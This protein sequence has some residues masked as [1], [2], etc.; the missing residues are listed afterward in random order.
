MA[1]QKWHLSHQLVPFPYLTTKIRQWS[2]SSFCFKSPWCVLSSGPWHFPCPLPGIF[3]LWLFTMAAIHHSDFNGFRI[4]PCV[5]V[6][7]Q[8]LLYV[9]L[10][11]PP[12]Y[13]YARLFPLLF[14]LNKDTN[15]SGSKAPSYSSMTYL[16]YLY[17]Q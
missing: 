7:W 11:I 14:F 5:L 8:F 10:G 9:F 13:M 2:L 16:T 17:L 3:L 1:H 15:N 6:W 12:V 4:L